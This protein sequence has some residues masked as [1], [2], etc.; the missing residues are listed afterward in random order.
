ML[1]TFKNKTVNQDFLDC[2]RDAYLQ[3]HV[4]E[5]T[6]GRQGQEPSTLDLIITPEDNS[7]Q[8]IQYC[9]PL[10]KSDH[11]CLLFKYIYYSEKKQKPRKVY[12]YDRGNYNQIKEELRNRIW[13]DPAGK[14]VDELYHDFMETLIEL[15]EKYIPSKTYAGKSKLHKPYKL[16]LK[17]QELIKEKNRAWKRYMRN[18]TNKKFTEFKRARNRVTKRIKSS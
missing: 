13:M 3:Q 9:S 15:Q 8:D 2:L 4:T 1:T 18:K 14:G 5:P 10:G 6:R 12:I 16:S 17:D 11:S 7:V